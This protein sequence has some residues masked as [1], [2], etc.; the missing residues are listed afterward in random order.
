[1]DHIVYLDA[2]AREIENLILGNKSMI[3]RGTDGRKMPHGS[4]NE[5][6]ILYFVYHN[7]EEVISARGKVSTVFCSGML[8]KEESYGIIIRNQDKLQLPDNQFA[9]IAGKRYLVLIGLEK[10]ETLTPFR[11]DRSSFTGSDDWIPVG[12]IE[13]FNLS[14]R[15]I[16]ST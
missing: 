14:D 16:I 1:M 6:D 5:G 4:V 12:S 9:T 3:I 11:F 2:K 15:G 7:C 10:I 8:T 13:E